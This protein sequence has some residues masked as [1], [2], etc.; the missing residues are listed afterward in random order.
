[1]S[2]KNKLQPTAS[3]SRFIHYCFYALFF[4]T[5][6]LLWPFTSEVFEFNKMMFVYLM[7]ILIGAAWLIRA[8]NIK[9]FEIAR[10][11]L[12]IPIF[13]FLASQIISTI[14]SIDPHTSVWGYY[15][16]FH[17]GLASTISYVVL[18]YAL[19]THFVG[20]PK[21]IKNLI[22]AIFSTAAITSL[23]AILEK[24]GIDKNIWIQD[25]QN[26]VFSTLGQPN[27][28]SAYLIAILPLAL[29]KAINDSNI[30]TRLV[31]WALSLLF[32]IVIFFTKSQSGIGAAILVLTAFTVITAIQHKKSKYLLLA[33]PLI[34]LVLFFKGNSV[35]NTLN[36]LNKINP[37]YSNATA[38]ITEENKTRVGGSDSMAIRR[39]VWQGAVELG[40]KY[41][42][43]G[44]GV[45]T[46]G[47]TYYWVRP[48]AHNLTSEQDF[49]Y[50]KAHN[51]FLNFLANSGFVGLGTYLLLIASIIFVFTKHKSTVAEIN[52]STPLLLG[53]ISILITNYF[54]FSVV[55]VALFFFLFPAIYLSN[56]NAIKLISI[57]HNF[58][59]I[60]GSTIV[61]C[62]ALWMANTVKNFWL[63]D[64]YYTLG[65]SS[66]DEN[67]T[68]I[69]L[70][71]NEPVYYSQLGNIQ[72]LVAVQIIAPQIKSMEAST[73]AQL[74]EKANAYLKQYIADS[75]TNSD[76]AISMNPYNLN[77]LKSKARTQ[78]YLATIDPKFNSD[79]IDTLLKI[80]LLSP[81]EATNYNNLGILYLTLSKQYKTESKNYLELAKKAFEKAIELKPDYA[82]AIDQLNQIK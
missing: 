15:S 10:T 68:A 29:Y 71:P 54:G 25:V 75:I 59:S 22:T 58:N 50:N 36:S 23:Y 19:V 12:D 52:I 40:K 61:I 42:F 2:P 62:L 39:V 51:E 56:T 47:Y 34:I 44:T 35:K 60:L 77:V 66:L 82:A 7:T 1:M 14:I 43:F 65:K 28:L 5:P 79:A 57:K 31:Y 73:P 70:N 30:K 20:Q 9:K 32:L 21:A 80:T 72:A 64:I 41:P 6:L 37:F 38:I 18:Y 49:L 67:L 74:R 8:F 26:R 53:F 46:F 55:N 69:K 33:I 81:T 3:S 17:G 27:W 76:K 13:L 48:A 45:E 63:A 4:F 78:L 11:P 16:R 24:L